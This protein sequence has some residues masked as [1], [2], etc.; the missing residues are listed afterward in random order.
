MRPA[1]GSRWPKLS[2][3]I[4]SRCACPIL[5]D[6]RRRESDTRNN[7]EREV[8]IGEV[9]GE[10]SFTLVRKCRR[11][12]DDRALA[13]KILSSEDDEQK[14]L[15]REEFDMLQRMDSSDIVRAVALYDCGTS[16]FLCLELGELGSVCAHIELKGPFSVVSALPLTQQLVR[17]VKYIHCKRII[18]CDLKHAN[19]LLCMRNSVLAL[20]ICDFNSAKHVGRTKTSLPLTCRG[21]QDFS[22]PEY[23]LYGDWN[24]RIDI[25]AAGLCVYYMIQGALPFAMN[26]KVA[27][28]AVMTGVLPQ[29]RWRRPNTLMEHFV[30][31]CLTL[32]AHDRP[33]ALELLHHPLFHVKPSNAVAGADQPCRNNQVEGTSRCC[34]SSWRKREGLGLQRKLVFAEGCKNW[35]LDD[36]CLEDLDGAL[37]CIASRRYARGIGSKGILDKD[38]R[39]KV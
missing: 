28:S 39:A 20:K 2:L 4:P 38:R 23:V 33:P 10:G 12:E 6:R 31:S 13:V 8:E 19:L 1:C 7:L 25:W 14:Q 9:L 15:M 32:R 35:S 34:A 3:S 17:G 11:R 36:T 30:H 18:H 27:A 24:E 37:R 22:A 29:L 5:E 26:A 16:V 21:T